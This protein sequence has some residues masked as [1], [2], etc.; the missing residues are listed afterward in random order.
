MAKITVSIPELKRFLACRNCA[1]LGESF[2][3]R[4][5]APAAVLV[6]LFLKGGEHHLLFTQRSSEV[7][8]YKGHISFPGGAHDPQDGSPLVTALRESEEEVGLSPGDVEVVGGLD[9]IYSMSGGFLITPF[10]G[11][12]PYPYP[13]RPRPVEV[14][15]LL[16][17]P[18]SHLL[19]PR[20]CRQEYRPD[21]RLGYFFDYGEKV[22]WGATA[23]I[24]RQL[25]DI[26]T[27]EGC[28]ERC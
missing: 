11:L 16:E 27:Q 12:I 13:F 9:P 17:V 6:P 28:L 26:A 19:E 24:T 8:H 3:G 21:G 15:H 25:L 22:I 20:C 1:S 5:F 2:Q 4:R 10:V 14:A 7:E 23:L 18:L